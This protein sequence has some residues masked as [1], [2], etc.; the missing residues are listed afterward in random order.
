MRTRRRFL[1]PLMALALVVPAGSAS[2]AAPGPADGP[3]A[4]SP[5]RSSASP[6]RFGSQIVALL[7]E[8]ND[9][10]AVLVSDGVAYLGGLGGMAIYDVSDPA[11]P[12]PRGGTNGWIRA[13]AKE[14]QVLFVGVGSID[15]MRIVVLDVADP[16]HPVVLA[17]INAPPVPGQPPGDYPQLGFEGALAVADGYLYA[18]SRHVHSEAEIYRA[19]DVYDVHDPSAPVLVGQTPLRRDTKAEDLALRDDLLYVGDVL[20]L[21]I[22]D[23]SDPTAPVPASEP[24]YT[25]NYAL[26][27]DGAWLYSCKGV[28][29]DIAVYSLSDPVRPSYQ[30]FIS[31]PAAQLRCVDIELTHPRAGQSIL[32]A[33]WVVDQFKRVEVYDVTPPIK[34]GDAS[35]LMDLGQI[36]GLP[37]ESINDVEVAGNYVYVAQADSGVRVARVDYDATAQ[38]QAPVITKVPASGRVVLRLRHGVAKWQF[39]AVLTAPSGDPIGDKTVKIRRSRDGRTW[40]TLGSFSTNNSGVTGVEITFRSRGTTYWRWASPADTSWLAARTSKTKVVVK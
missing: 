3:A 40:K 37:A 25:P 30:G 13:L 23:V 29:G 27:V 32:V 7:D 28:A 19:L 34:V 36:A 1:F 14:G 9:D 39:F 6:D 5:D 24:I 8:G 15:T 10:E 11:Q 26:A 33:G 16:N 21:E 2:G 12:L 22:V 4:A 17:Q 35:L 38:Q 31:S 18:P 20:W